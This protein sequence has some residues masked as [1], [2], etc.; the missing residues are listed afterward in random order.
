MKTKK[1][2]SL[3]VPYALTVYGKEEIAA[4]NKVLSD[5]TKIVSGPLVKEFE[6]KIA[7]LFGKKH[8]IMVN[9]GSSANLLA[10][11]MMNLEPG[12]EVITPILTF[13]T[14]VAPIVQKGLV[15]V[16]VDVKM[17]SYEIDVDKIEKLITKKT[18]ALMIPSLIGNLPDFI[19]LR[20]IA[21]KHKL[22]LIEDSCDTLG[23]KFAGK[24]TGFYSDISTTSFYASHIITTAGMGGMIS[25]HDSTL[26][27]KALIMSNW[28]RESTLFGVYE[29]S[30]EISKRF[31]GVLDGDMYDAKFIFS[32]CGYNFQITELHGAFGL[33]Q[34]KRLPEFSRRRH[35]NFKALKKFFSQY[36]D[37][38]FLPEQ[39]PRTDTNWLS[40]PLTIKPGAP[41]TR[42]EITKYLEEKNI[43]TRPI[44]TG[45]IL[46]QPGF[47][48]IKNR[49]VKGGYPVSEHIMK[50]GFLIGCHHGM[51]AKHLDYLM[52]TFSAFLKKK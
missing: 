48:H 44:F 15:P 33:E 30:E 35:A 43:Q 9:S 19:K 34:L 49:V 12:S 21:D 14:T 13:A 40:F 36:E 51:E 10:F 27:K 38:F 39:D 22:W 32:E 52:E 8:G 25:F 26:A 4:V 7:G 28:G 5:P 6:K 45:N 3:R 24:P 37:V 20:K 42:L 2:T 17:G 50:N 41:F 23:A 1:T 47:K 29:K 11:E 16:F 46:K 31:V 18:K